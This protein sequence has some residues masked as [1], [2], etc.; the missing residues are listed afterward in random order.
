MATP[1]KFETAVEKLE[2]IV[3]KLEN[4]D[5]TLEESLKAFEEGIGLARSCEKILKE[6]KGKVEQLIKKEGKWETQ[7]F[8]I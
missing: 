5:L 8:D 7:S 6:A 1:M 4:G 3:R 2:S